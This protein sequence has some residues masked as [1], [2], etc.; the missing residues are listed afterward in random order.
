MAQGQ[1]AAAAADV[2][3]FAAADVDD[4]VIIGANTLDEVGPR[5]PDT[6]GTGIHRV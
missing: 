4:V 5:C 2:D 6:T 1:H 3:A